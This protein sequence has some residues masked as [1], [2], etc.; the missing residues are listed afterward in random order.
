MTIPY[1]LIGTKL[2]IESLKNILRILLVDVCLLKPWIPNP[3]YYFSSCG[4]MWFVSTIFFCYCCYPMLKNVEKMSSRKIILLVVA[5]YICQIGI[6]AGT[7][8]LGASWEISDWICYIFPITKSSDFIIGI[9]LGALY[10]RGC[11]EGKAYKILFWMGLIF[12]AITNYIKNNNF[13]KIQDF[14]GNYFCTIPII[15][16][17]IGA[18]GINMSNK[19]IKNIV[20]DMAD[21]TM[22]I[23]IFHQTIICYV[24][25]FLKIS[26]RSWE[27]FIILFVCILYS[28]LI[29]RIDY[30][31]KGKK[32]NE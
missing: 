18:T 24:K 8:I 1:Y 9:M 21:R 29:C 23:F 31:I 32:K 5:I 13:F 22:I 28:E 6:K 11:F 14:F 7:Y 17:L 3:H 25:R 4:V 16:M 12:Y 2:N 26:S 30:Y 27:L 19:Y 20:T 15:V 10:R